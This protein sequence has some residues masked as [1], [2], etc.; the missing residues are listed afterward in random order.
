M[1]S[2]KQYPQF[3]QTQLHGLSSGRDPPRRIQPWTVFPLRRCAWQGPPT[4]SGLSK[5]RLRGSL[6]PAAELDRSAAT[7]C[8]VEAW[9]SR[10][11]SRTSSA[12]T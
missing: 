12:V 6:E 4:C 2:P 1:H 8:P 3:S 11:A 10:M 9:N 5:L 7:A